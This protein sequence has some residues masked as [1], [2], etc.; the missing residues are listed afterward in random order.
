M[1]IHKALIAANNPEKL[2]PNKLP[3][4]GVVNPFASAMRDEFM[5][6][7]TFLRDY[8]S[9]YAPIEMQLNN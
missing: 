6:K 3:L 2:P 8:Q 1:W 4:E 5:K 7:F 9:G